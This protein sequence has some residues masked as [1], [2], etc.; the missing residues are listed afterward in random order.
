M[1]LR[2]ETTIGRQAIMYHDTGKKHTSPGHDQE[3]QAGSAPECLSPVRIL[4]LEDDADDAALTAALLRKGGMVCEITRV[5]DHDDF[6]RELHGQRFDII[7][8]DLSLPRFSGLQAL[9][10]AKAH[11]SEVPFIFLS[12]NLGEE[13]AIETLLN[14]ARDYVLKHRMQRLVPAIARVLRESEESRKRHEAETEIARM[15]AWTNRVSNIIAQSRVVAFSWKPLPGWPV[16]FVSG[17]V[18]CFG[19]TAADFME[20]GLLFSD[21][22]HPDDIGRVTETVRVFSG[23]EDNDMVM[24]Y[25]IV[26][27]DGVVHW[28]EDQTTVARDNGGHIRTVDGVLIDITERKQH[29]MEQ[30]LHATRLEKLYEL[31]TMPSLD[32]DALIEHVLDHA[33]DLTGSKLGYIHFLNAGSGEIRKSAWSRNVQDECRVPIR[34]CKEMHG[35][36]IW[37]ECL[38]SG[39]PVI[40]DRSDADVMSAISADGHVQLERHMAIPIHAEGGVVMIAG[41]GNKSE[42]YNESDVRVIQ[43]MMLELWNMLKRLRETIEM[44]KLWRAVEHSPASI[45]VTDVN[46]IIEYANPSLLSMTGYALD[47]LL[48]AHVR[49]FRSGEQDEDFYTDLWKTILAGHVWQGTLRNRRKNG[50]LYWESLFIAPVSDHSGAIVNFVAVKEDITG[51]IETE[52]SLVAARKDAEAASKLKDHFIAMISHEI[53][54]P[55]NVIFGY[56]GLLREVY[57]DRIEALD[58]YMFDAIEDAGQRLTRT[59]DLLLAASSLDTGAYQPVIEDCNP[60]TVLDNVI[61]QYA[62]MA[63][64]K[65]LKLCSEYGEMNKQL[66]IDRFGLEQAVQN[67]VDNALKFTEQGSV[68]VAA[69]LTDSDCCIDVRDTGPGMAPEFL[70]RAFNLF[71]QETEGYSR[72]YEGLGLGLTLVRKYVEICGGSISVHSEPGK[73]SVFSMCFPLSS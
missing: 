23:S 58:H 27:P 19:Y 56:A 48:G 12:G 38:Q 37:K 40:C 42:P 71:T 66:H 6:I 43:L 46:G 18:S 31:A 4:H 17:N 39:R 72:P 15:Q 53:R 25:R 63:R 47:E 34:Q 14:G 28:V 30:R 16:S 64:Q 51:R 9:D 73:G 33:V 36:G 2:T 57:S 60:V 50:E 52:R 35:R 7:L 3:R 21:I 1:T 26:S 65:G 61:R 69:Y 10:I 54:T 29:E 62:H 22:I 41:V 70:Q 20:N 59:V 44:K 55:L 24:E 11:A 5:V 13:T 68:T 32:E 45:S 67:L 49:V 8:S